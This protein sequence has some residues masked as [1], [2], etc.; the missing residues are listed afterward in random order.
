MKTHCL[1]V[2]SLFKIIINDEEF[3]ESES[4]I[5]CCQSNLSCVMGFGIFFPTDFLFYS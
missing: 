5:A 2:N 3:E 4:L 1:Y